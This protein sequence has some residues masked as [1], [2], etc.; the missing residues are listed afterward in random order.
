MR[1]G[2]QQTKPTAL[3]LARCDTFSCIVER[4]P[5]VRNN[6]KNTCII[7]VIS[8]ATPTPSKS[9]K[10]ALFHHRCRHHNPLLQNIR[11]T[12]RGAST[13]TCPVRDRNRQSF[14]VFSARHVRTL[15]IRCAG[16]VPQRY[17]TYGIVVVASAV[18]AQWAQSHGAD[19]AFDVHP[20]FSL[21]RTGTQHLGVV[22]HRVRR[23]VSHCRPLTV[24]LISCASQDTT[25][26]SCAPVF[27]P[28]PPVFGA[29]FCTSSL[30]VH[31]CETSS[32]RALANEPAQQD[33]TTNSRGRRRRVVFVVVVVVFAVVAR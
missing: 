18:N 29:G 12:E 33:D 19:S 14:S 16:H 30:R 17:T 24:G 28:V 10:R 25:R 31:A 7:V 2:R 5:I 13:A 32:I 22:S 11:Q 8:C 1:R 21:F 26:E 3:A 4:T 6:S 23:V 9:A 15:D 20:F 27:A